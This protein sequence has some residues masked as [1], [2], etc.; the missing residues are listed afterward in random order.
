MKFKLNGLEFEI[1]GKEETVKSEFSQFKEFVAAQLLNKLSVINQQPLN[2]LQGKTAKQLEEIA[3]VQ[4]ITDPE[5]PALKEV[6]KR[7]LPKT[8]SDWI[9]IYAFY[10]SEYGEK[11]FTEKDI[12]NQYASTGRNSSTRLGNITNNIK[13]LLNKEYIK[14]H[15]DTEY[16]LKGKGKDYC[17]R[18]L[19]GN[20]TSKTVK[21]NKVNTKGNDT[22][23]LG[24]V[25]DTK[26]EKKARGGKAIDFI[27]LNFTAEQISSLTKFYES[28]KPKIQNE[29]VAVVVKWFCDQLEHEDISLEEINYLLSICSKVPTALEQVI[30]NM[31]GSKYRWVAK[32]E[33]NK[34]KLTSIGESYVTNKLPKG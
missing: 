9:L 2:T 28:K 11:N 5:I 7:D 1:E 13:S 29:E 20:S 16:F 23:V 33:N 14:V 27:D 19:S 25:E 22:N 30:I 21:R 31:K 8:E 6:V 17:L 34:V 10:S 32:S 15:N 26:K 4:T 24:S 12:R 3:D 18:I